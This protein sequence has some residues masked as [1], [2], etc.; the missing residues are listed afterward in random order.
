VR[1]R[2][3]DTRRYVLMHIHDRKRRE[4]VIHRGQ[5][6]PNLY[7]RPK[8]PGDRLDGHTFE[9][10]YRDELGKQRQKTLRS[11][12]VQRAIAEAE[13]YRT[14]VRRGEV[15]A[16]SRLTVAEVAEEYFG[17]TA[18]LVASGERSQRT[19]DL[20]RQRFEK[21]IAPVVGS[22]RVQDVRAEHASAILR[23]QRESGLSAWTLSGTHTILSAL[24]S[25]AVSRGYLSASP[26]A[27]LSR[28]EKPRQ[29]TQRE[30]R[31][32][33]DDEIRRL[34]AAATP[35]Y[36]AI[37]TTLAWTGLRVSEALG[38]RWEDIDFDQRELRVRFQLDE[39]GNLKRPKTKAGVRS[40]PLLPI[41][42]QTLREHRKAQLRFGLASP[43]SLVFTT[44]S[45][46]PLDRHNI[47]N[48]GIVAAADKA[49][50]HPAGS[51]TITTH[52][53]RRTFMSHLILGLG[54]DPVRVAKIAGHS[55]PSVTMNV[56]AE[57]FDKALHRDDLM[58]RIEKAG[59]GAL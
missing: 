12:S 3:R 53:L 59:L 30:A 10:I 47:R 39:R 51:T 55:S 54:L 56:Y 29:T 50:L 36:K 41:L 49:A 46:K 58:A 16:P 40:I 45:G 43:D 34:C 18:G 1:L 32:L 24:F 5:R 13:E 20:Y 8:P 17:V 31:R 38:L 4:P 21:H 6:I 37:V 52:D 27:R 44:A 35:R 22:R 7:K 23:R 14:Q 33:S 26:L 28:F 57:E 11:R 19:L 42:E 9:V 48:K 25:F 15:S 2:G